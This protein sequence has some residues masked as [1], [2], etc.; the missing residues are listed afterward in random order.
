[1]FKNLSDQLKGLAILLVVWIH[2]QAFFPMKWWLGQDWL[3]LGM[4]TIDQI[5]RICVPLFIF[6]SW[7]GL[8]KKYGNKPAPFSMF[9]HSAQKLLPLYLLW[10]GLMFFLMER[11]PKWAYTVD[12]PWWQKLFLGQADYQLYFVP[13]ILM[14]YLGYVVV[15]HLSDAAIK[16]GAWIVGGVVVAW[17]VALLSWFEW[18]SLLNLTI[19]ADQFQYLFPLTWLWYAWLGILAGRDLLWKKPSIG[20]KLILPTLTLLGGVWAVAD[21]WFRISSGA[22]VLLSTMFTRIPVLIAVTFALLSIIVWQKQLNRWQWPKLAQVGVASYIIYLVH[23]QIIRLTLSQWQAPL[24]LDQWLL[25]C[26]VVA[27]FLVM[28]LA[29]GK[30]TSLFRSR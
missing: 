19:N 24:P 6:L 17:Y 9:L 21:A 27:V 5:G 12:I 28:A 23:T 8:A 25:G 1:M 30:L 4:I 26:G 7:Y 18:S 29:G 2:I 14:F 16:K 13:M 10:S 22:S 15:S 3:A 11:V 20:V